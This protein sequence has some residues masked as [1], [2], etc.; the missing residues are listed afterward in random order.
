MSHNSKPQI[1]YVE[2]PVVAIDVNSTLTQ[3]VSGVVST[4][5]TGVLNR[6]V[7]TPI[8]QK[9]VEKTVRPRTLELGHNRQVVVVDEDV[10]EAEVVEDEENSDDAK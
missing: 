1:A 9:G 3:I 2:T 6:Y 5:L 10:V 7:I 4:V 8:V